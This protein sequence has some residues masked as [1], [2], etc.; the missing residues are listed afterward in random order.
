MFQLIVVVYHKGQSGQE[1][2]A[3]NWKQEWKQRPWRNPAYW[4]APNGLL[5]IVFCVYGVFAC[6]HVYVPHVCRVLMDGE[7]RHQS[8]RIMVTDGCELLCWCWESN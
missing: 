8:P 1:L 7:R 6:R 5:A 3:G 2:K 4:F